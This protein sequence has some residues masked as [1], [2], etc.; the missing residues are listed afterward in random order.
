MINYKKLQKP[1]LF[2]ICNKGSEDV[3]LFTMAVEQKI[4]YIAK[5]ACP[6][7]KQVAEAMDCPY[8]SEC[9]LPEI[10]VE[11]DDC[12]QAQSNIGKAFVDR[13][14][15]NCLDGKPYLTKIRGGH[16]IPLTPLQIKD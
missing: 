3:I 8:V 6:R 12:W 13:G 9:V 1:E 14:V 7:T 10:P 16:S 5:P 2:Q 15:S 11:G 4:I